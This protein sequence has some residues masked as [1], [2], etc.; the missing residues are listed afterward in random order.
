MFKITVCPQ[1]FVCFSECVRVRVCV[2]VCAKFNGMPLDGWVCS[3]VLFE[4]KD[5][6]GYRKAQWCLSSM[7]FC[8]CVFLKLQTD[9]I[10]KLKVLK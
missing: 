2:C 9:F 10:M 3:D 6:T 1:M 8:H 4:E 7:K 5:I